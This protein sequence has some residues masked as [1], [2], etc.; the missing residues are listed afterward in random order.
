MKFRSDINGLR[1][2]AVV[3]VVLFHFGIAGFE[4]GF[5]GVDIFFVISGYLMTGIIFDKINNG[6]FSLIQ[7]YLDRGRRIIPALAALCLI[8]LI[9]GWFLLVPS[10]YSA[11]GKH[12]ASSLGF[13][14]NVLFWR[15]S[16]YFDAASHEKWLLHTWS[17]SVE[18]QFYLAYPVFVLLIRKWFSAQAIRWVLAIAAV[19]SFFLSIYL[20]SRQP[21]A[22]F[23][24]LP[25]RA[26]EMMTGGLVYLFPVALT[27]R[28]SAVIEWGGLGLILFSLFYFRPAD[29]WPGWL[30]AIPTMGAVLAIIAARD[31]SCI[32]GNPAAQFLGKTSYSI[33]LWHWPVV[34]GLSYFAKMHEISWQLIGIAASLV[35]GYL[36]YILIET[37]TRSFFPSSR[38]GV[39]RLTCAV[40]SIGAVAVG[41]AVM[42]GV[43][44]RVSPAVLTADQERFNQKHR[45][46]SNH[47]SL[48]SIPDDSPTIVIGDSFADALANS[49]TEAAPPDSKER[50]T[51]LIKHGCPTIQKTKLVDESLSPG[52]FEFNEKIL[53]LVSEKSFRP[54]NVVVV[55]STGYVQRGRAPRIF[56]VPEGQSK[57]I[58]F[59]AEEYTRRYVDTACRIAKHHSVYLVKP[60]PRFEVNIPSAISRQLFLNGSAPDITIDLQKYRE[61]NS[62]I[63][64]AMTQ[65]R[66]KCGAH[67][68]DPAPYLC[69]DGK[70]MGSL[71]GRP[72]YFDATHLSEY[73]NRFL[74]PMF[75]QVFK[76]VGVRI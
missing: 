27:R 68:L 3:A 32:T 6:N 43:P 71:N 9:A 26:W 33:Y 69:P 13:L 50:I 51:F 60:I 65:A 1:A 37:R 14:S 5:A 4:G 70:C 7:F 55:N 44:A 59:S 53:A 41:V 24:L 22:A 11:L 25:T 40:A 38:A 75:Q 34:V 21:S 35:L 30:A 45:A 66:A 58:S 63:L 12:A 16:G 64:D 62:L 73:G 46:L 8:L 10:D 42:Q 17:L 49:I 31:D 28:R 2:I 48:T 47:N 76:D 67:L 20:S 54:R 19:L 61:D 57:A 52:C 39:F 18:W 56:F 36:S 72:L 23:Y 29:Q 15:E 74:V